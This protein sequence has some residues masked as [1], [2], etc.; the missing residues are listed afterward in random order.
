MLVWWLWS[1]YRMPAYSWHTVGL[2]WA[3]PLWALVSCVSLACHRTL[4]GLSY[5]GFACLTLMWMAVSGGEIY[6]CRGEGDYAGVGVGPPH[7]TESF[8]ILL[9]N[10]LTRVGEKEVW[11]SWFFLFFHEIL[12]G[13]PLKALI[14]QSHL[15]DGKTEPREGRH[16]P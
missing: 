3:E 12:F 8:R 2:R 14:Q 4:P 15:L 13:A 6:S 7:T 9:L 1:C 10:P 11:G 5:S 16:S